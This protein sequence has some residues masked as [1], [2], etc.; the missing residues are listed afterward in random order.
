MNFSHM[1]GI[2]VFDKVSMFSGK[3]FRFKPVH[4]VL[5]SAIYLASSVSGAET[6]TY[7]KIVSLSLKA[8]VYRPN[9]GQNTLGVIF[10]HGGA[11]I[12]G[13]LSD[14]SFRDRVY[15]IP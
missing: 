4:I 2:G 13:S 7:K 11:C 12:F 8:D 10:L 6:Y 15:K 1:S 9:K 3:V 14:R 5:L